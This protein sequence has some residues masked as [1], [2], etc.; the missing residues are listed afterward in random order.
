VGA[1]AAWRDQP[2]QAGGNRIDRALAGLNASQETLFAAA[3]ALGD[4]AA[5]MH[6]RVR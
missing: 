1:L 4:A 6:V 2:S 3:L 5:T